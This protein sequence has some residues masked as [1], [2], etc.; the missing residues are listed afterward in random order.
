MNSSNVDW[1]SVLINW[2]P[3]LLI[4]GVWLYFIWKMRGGAS[5]KNYLSLATRQ[6]EALERIAAALEKRS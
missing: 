4:V 6:A 2:F 1:M 3:L 5:Q